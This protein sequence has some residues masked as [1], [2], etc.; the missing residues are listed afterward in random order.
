[1]AD[2]VAA[3]RSS[4][5]LLFHVAMNADGTGC[6]ELGPGSL[7]GITRSGAQA[8]VHETITNAGRLVETDGGGKTWSSHTA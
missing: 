3:S 5:R 7:S 4:D 2:I 6:V 1:V 8:L